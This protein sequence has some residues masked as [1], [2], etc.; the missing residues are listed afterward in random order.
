MSLSVILRALYC[1]EL[2]LLSV[3]TKPSFPWSPLQ[4]I[5]ETLEYDHRLQQHP[6]SALE[7]LQRVSTAMPKVHGDEDTKLYYGHLRRCV[8]SLFILHQT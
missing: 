2:L 1:A 8:F 3:A 6:I 7:V 5:S 4:T